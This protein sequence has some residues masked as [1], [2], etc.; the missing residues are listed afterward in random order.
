LTDFLTILECVEGKRCAKLYRSAAE[1]PEPYDAGFLFTPHRVDVSSLAELAEQ[2]EVLRASPRCMLIRDQL[3]A[4]AQPN[5]LGLVARRRVDRPGDPAPFEHAPH[6]W[7]M[8]DADAT[9]APFDPADPQGSVE[10][11]RAQLP[12]ALATA[13][14]VFQ[15]S[16]S[17][18]L[19]ETVRGHLFVWLGELLG[20]VPLARWSIR[21]GLDPAV[22]HAV[23]P[24]YTADPVFADG[25]ADPLAPRAL[26][27]LAGTETCELDLLESDFEE[28]GLL[29]NSGQRLS[30]IALEE[31]GD[32]CLDEPAVEAR[33]RIAAALGKA[34][35]GPGKRWD[36]C[37]HIGG[38]CAN[39]GLPPEE[40]CA[41]LEI[42][43]APD[44]HDGDF[45][46]GLKWALGAYSF[47]AKPLGLKGMRELLGP[48][49]TTRI[50]EALATLAKVYEPPPEPVLDQQGHDW[51]GLPF[52]AYDLSK[53]L[54]PINHVC[55]A[56]D[57]AP[58]KPTAFLSYGGT[59]KTPTA[60]DFAVCVATG[61]RFQGHAIDRTG[62]VLFVATEGMRNAIRK[63]HRICQ[64]RGLDSRTVGV[65]PVQ[66]PPGFLS[67]E[68]AEVLGNMAVEQG[69]RVVVIDTY[70]SAFDGTA[71]RN[72]NAFSLALKVL[73]DI[74]DRFD[75]T[76]IVLL[77]T[78]KEDKNKRRPPT[79]QDIDGHNSIGGALQSAVG[80]WRPDDRNKHVIQVSCVRALD[81]GFDAY[82]VEW[83][84]VPAGSG[85]AEP[86]LRCAV[87]DVQ[88][89][90]QAS[91][92]ATT[93]RDIAESVTQILAMVDAEGFTTWRAIKL[94]PLA[95]PR[96]EDGRRQL[97]N[98]L[99]REG[100]LVHHQAGAS[101]HYSRPAVRGQAS[102]NA[103]M[104]R[105]G[106]LGPKKSG[107]PEK[108]EG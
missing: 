86:G 11:W 102:V 84:D 45:G 31:I 19:S 88:D 82:H 79:L 51:K 24:L 60:L 76:F 70:N 39:A 77:H 33:Q 9:A 22:F 49:V 48:I 105:G 59:S 100:T 95:I 3:R 37:G 6:H 17:Q 94:A 73:G 38:A 5:A 10:R 83:T 85:Q 108:K 55:K 67:T 98:D 104:K 62:R 25:A 103:A 80:L 89:A 74:S 15:F 41:V 43:R 8:F 27:H 61:Q 72:T 30:P 36:L 69:Y 50:G 21:N 44:I 75:I 23:Q 40:A 52:E 78:R 34:F 12:K 64:A 93:A 1:K 42:L 66:A 92:Q 56:L 63:L 54:E 107:G 4:D 91:E 81:A 35:E 46:A 13:R 18:H 7:A 2:L 26:V 58:G 53:P 47:S 87:V 16:A 90:T 57:I 29:D 101:N 65:K 96:H 99:V 20:N 32:P 14:G 106:F 71:D 68:S 28:R 97:I